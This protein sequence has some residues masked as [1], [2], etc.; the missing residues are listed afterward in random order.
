MGKLQE[1]QI[2]LN[3]NKVVYSPGDSISGTVKISTAQ[4]IQCKGKT[5]VIG[6][7]TSHTHEWRCVDHTLRHIVDWP[8]FI[9][10]NY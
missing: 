8:S 7:L 10:L 6:P 1:F 9:F 2:T 4:P 3:G 5:S